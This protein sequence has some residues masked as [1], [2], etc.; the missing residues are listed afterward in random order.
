M[1]AHLLQEGTLVL[2]LRSDLSGSEEHVVASSR[3][4]TFIHSSEERRYRMLRQEMEASARRRGRCPHGKWR[5]SGDRCKLCSGEE[6][7]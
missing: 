7:G 5:F 6:A 1:Y 4:A 2:T 3:A